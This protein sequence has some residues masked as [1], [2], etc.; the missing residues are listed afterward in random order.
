MAATATAVLLVG[1]APAWSSALPGV[2]RPDGGVVL[3]VTVPETSDN[4]R[5]Q[6]TMTVA[7]SPVF[8]VSAD[9]NELRL[10]NVQIRDSRT[11]SPGWTVIGQMSDLTG[12]S[13]TVPAHAIGWQPVVLHP[14]AGAVPGP[15][16]D[17]PNGLSIAR[18]LASAPPGH[19]GPGQKATLTGVLTVPAGTTPGNYRATLT[20]TALG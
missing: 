19:G 6:F 15:R 12:P 17:D 1:A 2:D 5:E 13:E 16:V 20:L 9:S 11:N 18:L 10:A 8:H 14:G 3:S 4:A 7:R